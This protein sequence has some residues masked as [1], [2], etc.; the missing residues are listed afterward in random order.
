MRN[1]LSIFNL[2]GVEDTF[3]WLERHAVKITARDG[4]PFPELFVRLP[5]L[6]LDERLELVRQQRQVSL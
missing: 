3:N 2:W 6:F 4:I 5:A 1:P